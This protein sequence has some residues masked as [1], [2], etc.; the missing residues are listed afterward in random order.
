[1]PA[2]IPPAS[3]LFHIGPPKTGS[4]ALQ[5]SFDDSRETLAAHGVHYAGEHYR[6]RRAG[7]ALLG[8]A[9]Q[10]RTQPPIGAWERLVAECAEHRDVRVCLSNEDLARLTDEGVDRAVHDLGAERLHLVYVVR[11]LAAL[12]PSQWQEEVKARSV[13]GYDDWLRETLQSDVEHGVARRV[14]QPQDVAAI[15]ARWR[16]HLRTDQITLICADPDDRELLPRSFEELLDLPHGTL[17]PDPHRSNQ[18]LSYPEVEL[19]RAVNEYAVADG[20]TGR[21]YWRLVQSGLLRSLA[22]APRPAG[23]RRIPPMPEWAK[24]LLQEWC[25]TQHR[26]VTT[27]GVQVIGDPERLFWAPPVDA[28]DG[29]ARTITEVP[30]GVAAAAIAGMAIGSRRLRQ[31]EA[32]AAERAAPAGAKVEAQL[33]SPH[34]RD[35]LA[36]AST[37]CLLRELGGRIR[38]RRRA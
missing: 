13:L 7:W 38:R 5:H 32:R 33:A 20:W 3:L 26:A 24:P 22:S 11:P 35:A 25:A 36:T 31:Q 19:V 30:L 18:S 12:L 34:P 8:Y 23:A 37:R 6:P 10:G 27:S 16:R 21:E 4:T 28:D 1:M 17:A 14:W 9:P 2:P 29:A 15:V